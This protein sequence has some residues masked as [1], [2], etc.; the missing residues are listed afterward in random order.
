MDDLYVE[1]LSLNG[2]DSLPWDL[3]HHMYARSMCGRIAVVTDKPAELMSDTLK[4]W[5]K[6][7]RQAQKERSDLRNITHMLELSNEI[8]FMQGLSFAAIPAEL[9]DSSVSFGTVEHHIQHPP[10]CNTLYV[11]SRV[12]YAITARLTRFLPCGALV[13][14]ITHKQQCEDA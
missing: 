4:Q 1:R 13:T 12:D 10:V 9:L 14:L 11:T 8:A 7:L 6:V 2:A 5:R 3:A